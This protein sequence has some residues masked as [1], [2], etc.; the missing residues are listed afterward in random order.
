VERFLLQ[1]RN[2]GK[3]WLVKDFSMDMNG[4]NSKE[5]LNIISLGSYDYLIGMDWLDKNNDFLDCYKKEFMCLDEKGSLRFIQGIP[6]A[7]MVRKISIG[8]LKRSEE[9]V[10]NL[11]SSHRRGIQG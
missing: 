7:I 3:Y 5:D 9:R 1:I 2:H 6:R 11:R 8:K 4:L 10:S